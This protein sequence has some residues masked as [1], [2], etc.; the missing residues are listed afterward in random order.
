MPPGREPPGEYRAIRRIQK[1]CT[2]CSL[3]PA[4]I[5]RGNT[6]P[7]PSSPSID[8]RLAASPDRSSPPMNKSPR[9]Q[10][11]SLN[12]ST[13]TSSDAHPRTNSY[14]TL[15]PPHIVSSLVDIYF[16]RVQNQPYCFFHEGNFRQRFAGGHLPDHLK[17]AVL[18]AALRFSDDPYY[19][20]A[21]REA[22]AMYASQSWKLLLSSWF[23]TESDPDIHI[24]QTI[25]LLSII[26]YTA[27]RRHPAWLKIGMAIRVAQDL[28]F[29]MEPDLSL[30]YADQEERRR[31]FWSIYILDKLCSCSRARPSAIADAHC[32]VQ[33]PCDEITFRNGACKKM[34]TLDQL[35]S[36]QDV[37]TEHPGSLALVV[38]TASI[39]GRLNSRLP[40]WDSK[41]DFA[42]IYTALLQLE[43]QFDMGRNISDSLE[44]DCIQDGA[45]DMQLA[46]PLI[47]YHAIFQTCQCLLYHPFLLYQQLQRKDLKAP[48]SFLNR[49][50]QTSREHARATSQ[51]VRDARS[52]GCSIFYSFIGYCITVA[53]GVHAL[54]L[55][56]RDASISQEAR[57]CLQLDILF[58]VEFSQYWKC[59]IDMCGILRAVTERSLSPSSLFTGSPNSEGWDAD[60][61]ECL[62]ASVD[63]NNM[64]HALKSSN[65][66]PINFSLTPPDYSRVF[67]TIMSDQA[68]F[69]SY[70]YISSSAIPLN[71]QSPNPSLGFEGLSPFTS[72]FGGAPMD[73]GA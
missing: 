73:F 71:E 46:G 64:T 54:F 8:S 5:N 12:A 9:H 41:S 50:L 63:Y 69:D 19:G 15:P 55:N 4:L 65:T 61:L 34:P 32:R 23:E 13:S 39:L 52:L 51:L 70:R 29:M 67:N 49:A 27:G 28:C 3:L 35:L 43:T 37:V 66:S 14:R 25:T 6:E 20:S 21:K 44:E 53:G 48:P 59:G 72:Y 18:A 10:Q 56:D 47:F 26:D 38:L 33:L 36:P 40:P 24:C 31:V 1:A 57:D 22:T 42:T 16:A 58:L 17:F 11:T 62:W 2:N 7:L 68:S 30:T 60:E 45:V